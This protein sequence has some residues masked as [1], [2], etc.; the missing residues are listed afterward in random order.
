[1]P[2]AQYVPSG[3]PPLDGVLITCMR[4]SPEARQHGVGSLLLREAFRDLA[5]RGERSVLAYGTT[6]TDS[7]DDCPVLGAQFLVRNG[8]VVVRSHPQLPLLRA[9]LRTLVSWQ[10]N[11]DALLESLRVPARV[12][13]SAPAIY[14]GVRTE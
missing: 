3:P 12:P 4:M 5:L 11:L 10:A 2:Q 1:V 14:V 7:I 8:F 9:D 13:R 6:R